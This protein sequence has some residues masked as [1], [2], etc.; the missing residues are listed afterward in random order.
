MRTE[1]FLEKYSQFK[2]FVHANVG[3]NPKSSDVKGFSNGVPE[4]KTYQESASVLEG[5]LKLMTRKRRGRPKLPDKQNREEKRQ[6][7][8]TFKSEVASDSREVE[9]NAPE[10][11]KNTPK[12]QI[13]KAKQNLRKE[14]YVNGCDR[15]T[16]L[17]D[18]Q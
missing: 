16:V 7:I 17:S 1:E 18:I 5:E 10:V 13:L 14:A 12:K 9:S 2:Q 6:A 4:R 8:K 11:E 3:F 15:K